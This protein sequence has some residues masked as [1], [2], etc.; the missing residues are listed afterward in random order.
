[1]S[2]EP[3]TPLLTV[4]DSRSRPVAEIA[5]SKARWGKA[6]SLA[7]EEAAGQFKVGQGR[8][9]RRVTKVEV[10]RVE[11]QQERVES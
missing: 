7:S 1:M 9:K 2:A 6:N 11:R 10:E 4:E 8:K 3:V 5:G